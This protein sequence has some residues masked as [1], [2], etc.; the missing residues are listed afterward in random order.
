MNTLERKEN[1]HQARLFL[2]FV[3]LEITVTQS[4]P[5]E[6]IGILILTP[7]WKELEKKKKNQ[8]F[9]LGFRDICLQLYTFICK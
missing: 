2:P 5:L 9:R 8:K 6:L 1:R 4:G 7:L 3:L